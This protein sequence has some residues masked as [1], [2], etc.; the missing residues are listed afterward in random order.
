MKPLFI[1]TVLTAIGAGLLMAPASSAQQPLQ[2]DITVDRDIELEQRDA[3]RLPFTPSFTLPP[4]SSSN[5]SYNFTELSTRVPS[6]ITLL[7][8]AAWGDELTPSPY[9]GYADVG[10]FPMWNAAL[11]AGYRF[12]DTSKTRLG[13]WGQYNG[14]AYKRNDYYWRDNTALVGAAL[15]HAFTDKTALTAGLHYQYAKFTMTDCNSRILN[16]TN[17]HIN[18]VGGNLAVNTGTEETRFKIHGGVERFVDGCWPTNNDTD[19]KGPRETSFNIGISAVNRVSDNL[20]FALGVELINVASSNFSSYFNDH[21]KQ[22]LTA[23]KISPQYRATLNALELNIGADVWYTYD[24]NFNNSYDKAFSRWRFNP[25]VEIVFKPSHI[26]A[27]DVKATG[28]VTPNS[29]A[30][31]YDRAPYLLALPSHFSRVPLDVDARV[32][33]GP[34]EGFYIALKGGY[35]IAK[36][37]LMPYHINDGQYGGWDAR[38]IK[39]WRYGLELGASYQRLLKAKA[40]VM[41]ASHS[42][43]K[44]Y[45]AWADHARWV[46]NVQVALF[47]MKDLEVG[48]SLDLRLK[49]SIYYDDFYDWREIMICYSRSSTPYSWPSDDLGSI[50][51]LNLHGQ[52]KLQD[53]IALFINL[54]NI[55]NHKYTLLGD[56]PSQGIHGLVG[57]SVVF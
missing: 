6:Q 13:L 8:P 4:L 44:G 42:D 47:P 23:L 16:P 14:V 3:S 22:R 5:L 17:Q 46:A 2:K 37:W 10:Y 55:L 25:A 15:S 9:R 20:K 38:D 19:S 43:G 50:T 57:V 52:Y 1:T 56:I 24:K 33:L 28:L 48:A 30:E 31:L 41:G 35:S 49:R 45:Y 32:A 26:V 54:N 51:N 18:R 7:E 36:D 21:D 27:L 40:E 29:L 34:K 39:G 11:S 53:D 12:I